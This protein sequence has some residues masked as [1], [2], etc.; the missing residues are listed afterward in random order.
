MEGTSGGRLAAT[1]AGVVIWRCSPFG[2][3]ENRTTS[4]SDEA[5]RWSTPRA[6]RCGTFARIVIVVQE[7]GRISA[8][9]DA[10]ELAVAT[11]L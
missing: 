7:I 5:A 9:V 4:A 3:L 2:T 6:G 8:V 10:N 1:A 11:A